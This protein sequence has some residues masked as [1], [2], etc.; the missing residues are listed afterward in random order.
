MRQSVIG[1]L[2]RRRHAS[3]DIMTLTVIRR[4][5]IALLPTV[6]LAGLLALAAAAHAQAP[7]DPVGTSVRAMAAAAGPVNTVSSP[8]TGL[9]S[10]MST[11]PGAPVPIAAAATDPADVRA[12]A[13]LAAYG[14]AFGIAGPAWGR[15]ERVTGPDDLGMERVRYRQLHAGI[16]VTAG[17]MS[18]HLK[19]ASVIAVHAKT[20]VVRDTINPTPSF[21]ADEAAAR[22]KALMDKH[23][24][25]MATSYMKPRLEV[26]NRGL[27]EGNQTPTRLAWFI[28]AKG[29]ELWQYIWIDA[30]TGMRLLNFSQLAHALARQVFEGND[31][32]TLPG[33]LVRSEGAAPIL[34]N[35]DANF[36]YDYSG[37]TY[38]YYLIQHGR[39][40][41][42]GHGMPIISTVHHCE[43][44]GC[45]FANAFWNGSQMV[46]GS[47]Y[48]SA[49][50]VVGHELTHGVTE[51]SAKLFYYMQ[52]G[53]LNE[54]FSDI[55]GE[56]VDLLN[57]QGTDTPGARWL[58]GEDL[59]GG[60][61][62]NMMFPHQYGQPAATSEFLCLDSSAA[63]DIGGV[64]INSGIPNHAYALMV[65]G[66]V[67][68]GITVHG[69]GLIKAGKIQYRALTVYLLSGSNFLDNY[70]S[71]RQ[72]CADLTP[73][74]VTAADC[75]E[76][77]KALDA[78]Q[79]ASALPCS[80]PRAAW[81]PLCPAGQIPNNVF[82]DNLENP[83][84]G[85]WTISNL[86][87]NPG[88]NDQVHWIYPVPAELSDVGLFA[89]SGVHNFFGVDWNFTMDSAIGMTNAVL[90]P[91]GARLQFNH[92][93]DFEHGALVGGALANFDGAV[94]E[95]STNNGAIWQDAGFLI[96][97][98]A[99]YGGAIASGFQNPL[100]GRNAFVKESFGYTASQLSLDSLAGQSVRF[101]FRIGTDEAV[102]NLPF[103][104][105]VDDVRIYTCLASVPMFSAVLPA[106]RS[107]QVDQPATAF[108]AIINAGAQTAI[109]VSIAPATPVAGTLVYQTANSSN[110][111]TG[112]PNT[113]V[114][115][116]AGATQNFVIAF[117]PSATFVPTNVAFT[118]SGTNAVPITSITG[119]NTL[120]LSS[121]NVPGP[122]IIALAATITPGLI[123]DLPGPG[124]VS[125]F[126]VASS[127]VGATA[128]IQVTANKGALPIVVT[129]CQTGPGA[130]CLNGGPPTE[131]V[132]VTIG[133]GQ[134]PT[135]SFFVTRQGT[136]PF[137]PAH[138]RIFPIFT[139]TANGYVVGE[140]SVAVRTQ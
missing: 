100:A 98:G 2:N 51:F 86:M 93:F 66:G 17:E 50:D 48:A 88:P 99:T 132:T 104:W 23:F 49:D 68:N 54:S 73:G 59:P 74:V 123:V 128:T 131:S 85:N 65:D 97:S 61:I 15:V 27:L 42:D 81:T 77:T 106:G 116:P 44:T 12:A 111:L 34:G 118:M 57:G 109:N 94:I 40:S 133:A 63:S 134:T 76:V 1:P 87:S 33:T 14:A 16:P 91:P 39:D 20:L 82:F 139:N 135:F 115:I 112:T 127:N 38:D 55:F 28:E 80:P 4:T 125:A 110:A 79:M 60:A 41:I 37:D 62:R 129:V 78:V 140:T 29:A 13:F 45:P 11:R 83:A 138:N 95:Y 22:A 124:G 136:V 36:A 103:G 18:I 114:N 70:N 137:D 101:R 35:A 105:Y 24:P 43:A 122:D 64:H 126:A 19:G 6:V 9:V 58:I 67:Y 56:T 102:G 30:H 92:S 108:A 71:L 90:L 46:Y 26:F 84:S 53:A 7:A 121:L 117:T 21:S 113:P 107:V 10:F 25:G 47:G 3:E 75:A 89:T 8:L 52:S 32:P 96:T 119:L 5:R 72:S 120:M 31:G 130:A 69:I